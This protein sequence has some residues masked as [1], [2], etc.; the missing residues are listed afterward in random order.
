MEEPLRRLRNSLC[1][2][3]QT[4]EQQQ[5]VA[6]SQGVVLNTCRDIRPPVRKDNEVGAERL[7]QIT[8]VVSLPT[9][10]AES[11]ESPISIQNY[12]HT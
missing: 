3:Q 11:G 7:L 10:N 9:L 4:D 1:F 12:S 2:D 6:A 8:V 5:R